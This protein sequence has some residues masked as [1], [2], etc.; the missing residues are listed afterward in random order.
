MYKPFELEQYESIRQRQMQV[1]CLLLEGIGF[2]GLVMCKGLDFG[3]IKII[4]S[5]KHNISKLMHSVLN[6]DSQTKKIIK[7]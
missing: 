1:L 3:E 7:H 6:T 4:F 5:V 2:W